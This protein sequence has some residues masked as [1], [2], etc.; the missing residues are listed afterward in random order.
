MCP[1]RLSIGWYLAM[2]SRTAEEP[3]PVMIGDPPL[4]FGRNSLSSAT[5]WSIRVFFG[6]TCR[7]NTAFPGSS[8]F[9]ASR[10]ITVARSASSSARGEDALDPG[11]CQPV[12][13][14]VEPAAHGLVDELA[15]QVIDPGRILLQ[16]GDF[17]RRHRMR[18]EP[19]VR[20][21]L[22]QPGQAVGID[23]PLAPEQLHREEPARFLDDRDD[24]LAGDV[25]AHHDRVD[26]VELARVQEL[27]QAAVRPVDVGGEEDLR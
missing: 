1:C 7:L 20:D 18:V 23:L 10:S 26:S 25:T 6:G 3:T 12:L 22:V 19:G 14:Q 24:H 17:V 21:E 5:A 15:E 4:I 2:A 8:S 16:R 9:A 27:A 13:G 11:A